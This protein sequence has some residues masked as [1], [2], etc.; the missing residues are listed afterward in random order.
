MHLVVLSPRSV[1]FVETSSAAIAA[2]RSEMLVVVSVAP[3]DLG[4]AV[5]VVVREEPAR[6][7]L[8]LTFG[9]RSER[10]G[11]AAEGG[12]FWGA[13]EGAREDADEGVASRCAAGLVRDDVGM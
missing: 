10:T 9:R 13:G 1:G 3:E 12:G 2:V 11:P 5:P 4:V 6:A 8:D 7:A